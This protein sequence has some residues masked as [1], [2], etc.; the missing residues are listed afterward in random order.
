MTQPNPL[1]SIA[2]IVQGALEVLERCE[3][4]DGV[5]PVLAV[6][7][8]LG[9]E[10]ASVPVEIMA[11]S[12]FTFTILGEPLTNEQENVQQDILECLSSTSERLL[13]RQ[14]RM[15]EMRVW[16]YR[17]LGAMWTGTTVLGPSLKREEH[18]SEVITINGTND[19]SVIAGTFIGAVDEG[20]I[21]DSATTATGDLVIR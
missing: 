8:A 16:T 2:D 10:P 14:L 18:F 9:L 17:N 1:Q 21:G 4:D 5:A 19:A 13:Y 6:C 11:T 12:L 15:A 20:D 7:R 3:I